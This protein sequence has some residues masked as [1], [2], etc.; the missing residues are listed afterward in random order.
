M[1]P[2]ERPGPALFGA[3]AVVDAGA[4][5]GA[6]PAARGGEPGT[7]PAAGVADAG[8]AAGA[9]EEAGT[10]G[11]AGGCGVAA[12]ELGGMN[13]TGDANRLRSPPPCVQPVSASA[14]PAATQVAASRSAMRKT[15][16]VRGMTDLPVRSAESISAP[17]LGRAPPR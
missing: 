8:A 4:E 15:G 14:T 11:K 16:A 12:A 10:R 3:G 5:P 7:S 6:G 9:D 1:G 13:E 17:T 2:G